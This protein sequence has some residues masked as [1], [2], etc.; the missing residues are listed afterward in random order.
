LTQQISREGALVVGRNEPGFKGR[1]QDRRC[2]TAGQSSKQQHVE[3]CRVLREARNDVGHTVDAAETAATILVGSLPRE[4]AQNTARPEAGDE[5]QCY[6]RFAETVSRVQRIHVWPLKPVPKDCADV[7]DKVASLELDKIP[8]RHHFRDG[9][10]A[11][12]L[13]EQE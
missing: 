1:K 12:P 5:E 13:V 2:H 10:A 7:D 9:T 6:L 8:R 4:N 3:V 11:S